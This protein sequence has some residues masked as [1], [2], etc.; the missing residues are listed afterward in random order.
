MQAFTSRRVS[1]RQRFS[2]VPTP[3][4]TFMQLL[5]LPNVYLDNSESK[6]VILKAVCNRL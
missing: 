1:S 3:R 4:Q 5:P 6:S 2:A